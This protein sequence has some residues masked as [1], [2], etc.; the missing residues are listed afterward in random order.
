M[1]R[2]PST[3]VR[4][5]AALVLGAAMITAALVAT[6]RIKGLQVETGYR[7]HD[8]RGRLVVLEQ[9]RAALDVEHAALSR[10]QRLAA[11]A[12]ELGLVAPT[13]QTTASSAVTPPVTTKR[14]T[15][16]AP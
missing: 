11:I 7:I 13:L 6:V 3:D 14:T 2:A 5:I 9:Q 10:P 4:L 12:A 1:A 15:T 16:V 8:L